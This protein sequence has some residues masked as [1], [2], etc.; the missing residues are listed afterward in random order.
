MLTDTQQKYLNFRH[1]YIRYTVALLFVKWC[2]DLDLQPGLHTMGRDF[3]MSQLAIRANG[4]CENRIS[5]P[6][7]VSSYLTLMQ[8]AV[9]TQLKNQQIPCNSERSWGLLLIP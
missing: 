3:K 1:N 7:L 5:K 6:F 9:Q 8:K 4:L 2:Y